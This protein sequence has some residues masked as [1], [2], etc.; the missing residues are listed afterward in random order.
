MQ[1]CW[2]WMVMLAVS[3]GLH[4]STGPLSTTKGAKSLKEETQPLPTPPPSPQTELEPKKPALEE[5][6]AL[7]FHPGVVANLNGTWE[8]GDQLLNLPKEVSLGISILKPEDLSVNISEEAIR[9][10][11]QEIF[12]KNGLSTKALSAPNS[13]PLPF[14]HLEI[15]VY[16]IER[17]FV[18]FC[19]ARLF[20]SVTLSRFNLEANTAFQA[21]TWEKQLLHIV[22]STELAH[23]LTLFID[24]LM[25]SYTERYF[26]FNKR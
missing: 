18:T 26:I 19:Q 9:T 21:I 7:Y 1:N 14:L 3:F 8:G 11:A 5:A 2:M 6:K 20:E 23:Q 16:P 13:P 24:S 17:G 22:S 15:W 10:Q 12:K 4:A 25:T